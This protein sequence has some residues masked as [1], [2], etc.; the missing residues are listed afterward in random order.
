MEPRQ[1]HAQQANG[2]RRRVLLKAGLLAGVTLSAWPLHSCPALWGGRGGAAQARRQLPGTSDP[3]AT[4]GLIGINS[5][6]PLRCLVVFPEGVP[7]S[8]PAESVLG[9]GQAPVT[10]TSSPL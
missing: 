5:I 9:L 7:G 10:P 3:V 8:S 2:V 4:D 6:E 1:A